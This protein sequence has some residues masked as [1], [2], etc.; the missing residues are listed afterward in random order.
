MQSIKLI[1]NLSRVSRRRCSESN[2]D[3]VKKEKEKDPTEAKAKVV[4]LGTEFSCKVSKG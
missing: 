2:I 3:F 1:R 4:E